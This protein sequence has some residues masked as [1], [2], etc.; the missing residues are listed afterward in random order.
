[1]FLASALCDG[2]VDTLPR[3]ATSVDLLS[4]VERAPNDACTFARA[5]FARL[6]RAG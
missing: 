5:T 1:V 3:F 4:R 6:S 2:G